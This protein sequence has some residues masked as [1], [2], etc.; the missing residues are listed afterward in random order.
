MYFGDTLVS[1]SSKKQPVIS[2]SS[3]ESEYRALAQVAAELTWIQS[4]L[5]ELQF[6]LLETP[7]TWCDNLGASALASNPI[8]H[9]RTKHIELDLHFVRDKVLAKDLEIRY[10]PSHDQTA[11]CLTKSLSISRFHFLIDKL[12]VVETPLSLRGGVKE[13]DSA[14]DT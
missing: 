7:I 10:I 6:P 3:T 9:A 5:K 13:S 1:L 12:G 14:I 11:D 2:S 4:L 8:Y